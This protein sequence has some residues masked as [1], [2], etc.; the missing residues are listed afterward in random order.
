MT[1]GVSGPTMYLIIEI[2]LNEG[3]P[4]TGN[5]NFHLVLFVK[6]KLWL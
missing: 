6:L 4:G 1:M 3:I 2:C 5:F